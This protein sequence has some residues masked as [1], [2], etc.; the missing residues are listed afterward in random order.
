MSTREMTALE[1]LQGYFDRKWRCEVKSSGYH[2]GCTC[3]P[4]EPHAGWD[5]DWKWIA[6][7]LPDNEF[8]RQLLDKEE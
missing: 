8:F 6:P 5:C 3:S 2:N 1:R 7:A 4:D